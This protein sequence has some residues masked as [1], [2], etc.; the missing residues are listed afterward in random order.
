MQ[1]PHVRRNLGVI[2]FDEETRHLIAE[3]RADGERARGAAQ[4]LWCE[5]LL[6]SPKLKARYLTE[7]GF[8][9]AEASALIEVRI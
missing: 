3:M 2:G 7:F 5:F 1:P 6:A 8:N 4:I 9:P